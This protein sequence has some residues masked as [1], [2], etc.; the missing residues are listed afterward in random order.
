VVLKKARAGIIAAV[1]LGLSRAFG[2]T[3]AV[4]M[5]VGCVVQAPKSLFDTA[6]TLPALI[7]NNYGEMMSIPLYD[8]ALLLA[9]LIL[10][11][12]TVFFNVIA[13]LIL[14]RVERE[15]V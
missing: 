4:L 15:Y 12:V 14:L 6:Y 11:V 8:S 3:I 10:L 7:A 5:V 2:E 1:I 13:W 9:A